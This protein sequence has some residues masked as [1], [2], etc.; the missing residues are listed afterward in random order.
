MYL[1]LSGSATGIFANK[2]VPDR[3]KHS[4]KDEYRA[5]MHL[6]AVPPWIHGLA[7]RLAGYHHIPGN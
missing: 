7:V 3:M 6:S 1:L 5:S 4:I 2:N